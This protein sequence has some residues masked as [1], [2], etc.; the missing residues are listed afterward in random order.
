MR[1]D[2]FEPAFIQFAAITRV[3]KIVRD[4][5]EAL[6]LGSAVSGE[7]NDYGVF[8]LSALEPIERAR[9]SA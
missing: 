2:R 8:G 5:I 3:T 7:V 1:Q 6:S 9:L 4:Q